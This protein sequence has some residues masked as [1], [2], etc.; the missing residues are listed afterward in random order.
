VTGLLLGAVIFLISKLTSTVGRLNMSRAQSLHIDLHSVHA[1]HNER[2]ARNIPEVES[3]W[4]DESAR[5]SLFVRQWRMDEGVV[6]ESLG[7]G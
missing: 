5:S 2:K 4:A 3:E 1:D 6:D 7:I